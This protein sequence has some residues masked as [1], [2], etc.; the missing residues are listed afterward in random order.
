MSGGY[1][2]FVPQWLNLP[3]A[4]LLLTLGFAAGSW[5]YVYEFRSKTKTLT[6]ELVSGTS[7]AVLLGVGSFFLMLSCGLYV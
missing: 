1:E 2:P 7:A 5:F 3:L 4:V 6:I